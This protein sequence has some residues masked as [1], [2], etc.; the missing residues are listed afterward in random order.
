VWKSYEGGK[1]GEITYTEMEGGGGLGSFGFVGFNLV[2]MS[3][4]LVWS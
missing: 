1:A 2:H 3:L 4:Q